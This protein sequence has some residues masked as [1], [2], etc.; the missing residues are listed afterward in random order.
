M[1][2]K[3]HLYVRHVAIFADT[4]QTYLVFSVILLGHLS[5]T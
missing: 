1:C 4:Y 5:K 3:Y 2:L